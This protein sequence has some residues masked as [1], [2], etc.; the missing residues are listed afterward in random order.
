MLTYMKVEYIVIKTTRMPRAR[1]DRQ[2][3]ITL[4][5]P[6]CINLGPSGRGS[7]RLLD[8]IFWKDHIFMTIIM[9]RHDQ[10]NCSTLIKTTYQE[11]P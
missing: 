1:Q 8:M 6:R 3:L 2:W 9:T 7:C 4:G 10:A 11:L 5:P